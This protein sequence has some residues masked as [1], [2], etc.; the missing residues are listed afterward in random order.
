LSA[1]YIGSVT[2]ARSVFNAT[3][4]ARGTVMRARCLCGWF[5]CVET[6]G[7]VCVMCVGVCAIF[8]VPCSRAPQ[9]A[10]AAR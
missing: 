3:G 7:N 5:D 10:A 2:N 4:C 8:C 1:S 9:A 6:D